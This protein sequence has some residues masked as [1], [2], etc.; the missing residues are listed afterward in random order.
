MEVGDVFFGHFE[1]DEGNGGKV[2]PLLVIE[3]LEWGVR[4]CYGTSQQTGDPMPH[5][6]I[7]SDEEAKRTGLKKPT[8]F[9]LKRRIIAQPGTATGNVVS[10]GD[11]FLR[12]MRTAANAAGLF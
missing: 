2:R 10:L 3:V 4:V 6:L 1:N 12:R 11:H 9:N 5:E 8:R 7:L